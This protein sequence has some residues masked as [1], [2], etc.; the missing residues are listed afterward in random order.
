MMH[1]ESTGWESAD[2]I[3][4]WCTDTATGRKVTT[5]GKEFPCSCPCLC[6]MENH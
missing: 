3:Q 5:G 1:I 6:C 4:I 2:V